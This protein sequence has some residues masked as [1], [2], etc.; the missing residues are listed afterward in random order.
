MGRLE[1][2]V[3]SHPKLE[4]IARRI[5]RA[6]YFG[7][8][9]TFIRGDYHRLLQHH[10]HLE[11]DKQLADK[12]IY[13]LLHD[14]KRNIPLEILKA[15]NLFLIADSVVEAPASLVSKDIQEA[16]SNES[17]QSLELYLASK[18]VRPDD[19]VLD[20]ASGIGLKAIVAARAAQGGRVVGFEA[21]PRVAALA[22][23]N[24]ERN[25]L[26]VEILN[27]AIA[28]EEG[29]YTFYQGE[30]FLNNS[31]E[32]FAEG[33]KVTVPS[34]SFKKI[35]EEIRPNIIFCNRAVV[36]G[37]LFKG[38]DLS[39]VG[40]IV[41][42]TYA[43]SEGH[44]GIQKC[45]EDLT[46]SGLN[47]VEQLSREPVLV[48]DRDGSSAIIEPFGARPRGTPSENYYSAPFPLCEIKDP[49]VFDDVRNYRQNTNVKKGAPFVWYA[50]NWLYWWGGGVYTIIRFAK[51][52]ADRGVR[53]II[54]VYDNAGYPTVKKLRA[55]LDEAFPGHK[56][57][58]TADI[59]SLPRGHI[60]IASTYQST[61][62]VLRA[63]ECAARFYLMQEYESLFYT[64]GTQAEQANASYKL[65]FKGICGGDW[66][67]SIFQ[68]YGGEAIKFD[69]AINGSVFYPGPAVRPKIQKLFFFG[70]PS[71]DRR[72]YDL[73]VAVLQAIHKNYPNVEI[74][75]AGLD[76]L[77]RLPF[78]ATYLGNLTIEKTGEL[79]RTCDVG[80]TFSGSNLSYLPLELMACGVPVLTNEGPQLS[81]FCKHM[82]NCYMAQPFVSDFLRGFTALYDGYELRQRLV[83]RGLLSVKK[84]TWEKEADKIY[85]YIA[86]EV[87]WMG[88][89]AAAKILP[90]KKA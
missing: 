54:Y 24:A 12:E 84:T 90:L 49:S 85:D 72:M 3:R 42:E 59:S 23:A 46:A 15:H 13:R 70:R 19:T 7:D 58:F 47:K 41:V 86:T 79:Y 88:K 75:I 26:K 55:D 73:G 53:T 62:A 6:R 27:C 57:E 36:E 87:G 33:T 39:G 64:G 30:N 20:L 43:C 25:E 10:R 68:S 74:V 66:L 60:A 35:V 2:F 9:V 78:P 21:D 50:P 77:P 5:L 67:R 52:I 11:Y 29:N 63:P 16:L 14:P 28:A 38:A 56:I 69:F 65:G 71:S 89:D 80:L 31:L 44:E 22:K 81:W 8:A 1:S 34:A 82:E 18:L 48:F 37:R 45:I 4:A 61:F 76:D 32:A 83:A 40:R 17:Y 51:L